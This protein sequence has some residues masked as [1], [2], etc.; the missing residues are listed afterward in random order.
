MKL[1]ITILLALS[2]TGCAFQASGWGVDLG[3]TIGDASVGCN[4]DENGYPTG[5]ADC[6]SSGAEAV[7]AVADAAAEDE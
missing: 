5:G 4:Y 1:W 7:V 3:W 6:L 2:L